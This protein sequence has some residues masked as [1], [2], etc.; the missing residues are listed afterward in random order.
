MAY[1]LNLWRIARSKGPRTYAAAPAHR[2][3]DRACGDDRRLRGPE[4][5]RAHAIGLGTLAPASPALNRTA[6]H[7]VIWSSG[8]LVIWSSG[9]LVIWLS[10]LV[11]NLRMTDAL[12]QDAR[13][14]IRSLRKSPGFATA[15]IATI[16]LGVG[17]TTAIFSTVNAALLRPLPFRQSTDLYTLRTAIST[18]RPT[19]GLVA[20]LELTVLNEAK[21]PVLHATGEEMEYD[22]ILDDGAHPL[23]IN[24]SGVVEGYFETFNAPM[25][26]GRAFTADES[27]RSGHPGFAVVLS[28]HLWRT[29]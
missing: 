8:Y 13:Y 10:G 24:L 17:A 28:S 22:T 12:F 2:S 9:Y 18:G 19:S 21:G 15:A 20:P 29:A 16:A 4:P 1:G 27:P 11:D 14:A 23:Q 3:V 6:L 5:A 7:Q 25:T 26:L